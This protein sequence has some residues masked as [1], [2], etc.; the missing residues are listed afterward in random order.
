MYL[1]RIDTISLSKTVLI[2]LSAMEY[3]NHKENNGC[4]SEQLIFPMKI[5]KKGDK[6][7]DRISEQELRLLFIEEFKKAYSAFFYSIETPTKSKHSLKKSHKN[8]KSNSDGQSALI[9]MCIFERINNGYQRILNIEF[10]NKNTKY[11]NIGKDI[12]K[13]ISENNDGVF[14][15]LLQN[16]DRGTFC[17]E[18]GTG[19][20]DKF[21]KSFSDFQAKWNDE[22]KFI[23]L[24]IISLKQK[25]LIHRVLK[26]SDLKNLNNIF[27]TKSDCGNIKEIKGNGWETEITKE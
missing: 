16:T 1:E 5:Q 10:K 26:K 9:D 12:L 13:L 2:R 4:S 14:I 23:Q 15:H 3:E 24:I 17:N 8:I 27:F 25:T 19:I 20:F 21:R 18:R 11:E 6:F 22:H 7:V